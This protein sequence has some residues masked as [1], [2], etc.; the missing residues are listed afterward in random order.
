MNNEQDNEK[1]AFSVTVGDIQQESIR[2][3]GRKL[4]DEE[5]HTAMKGI[6]WGL[7]FDIFTVFKA[8]ID[9][10]VYINLKT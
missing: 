1:I 5:L 4:T 6:D 2:L 9:E 10:A 7:S 3:I 8:A